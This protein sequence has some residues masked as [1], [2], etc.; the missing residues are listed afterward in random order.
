MDGM[1]KKKRVSNKEA[2]QLE[3]LKLLLWRLRVRSK[4]LKKK[5]EKK[6]IIKVWMI[7]CFF[8]VKEISVYE[9]L[10]WWIRTLSVPGAVA[11]R[12]APVNANN[13]VTTRNKTDT[14]KKAETWQTKSLSLV[15]SLFVTFILFH[16]ILKRISRGAAKKEIWI[17]I[18]FS[19]F[20]LKK[21]SFVT[22]VNE[23][24][25]KGQ[26]EK[27]KMRR[28]KRKRKCA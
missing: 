21:I 13:C 6:I 5:E 9:N 25:Q 15:V 10:S 12:R 4:R 27:G 2:K 22:F 19:P 14:K 26:R 16:V 17:T 3:E 1:N 11:R 20:F 18:N 8:F 7:V 23:W 24:K 28:S